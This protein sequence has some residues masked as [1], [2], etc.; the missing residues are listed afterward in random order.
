[1][2]KS[3]VRLALA[4]DV[5]VCVVDRH[6]V[7]LDLGRDDYSAVPL[8]SMPDAD[9]VPAVVE[10][11]L[12]RELQRHRDDLRAAGLLCNAGSGHSGLVDFLAI[13]P[14]AGHVFGRDDS[15]C[16]GV[17]VPQSP[18]RIRLGDWLQFFLASWKA[19]RLLR[20]RH[21]AKIAAHVIRRKANRPVELNLDDLRRQLAIFRR[22][23][24]W[25]PRSYLCLWDSLALLEFLAA[26][27]HFPDWIYGVQVEPF[28][29]HCWLQV[30]DKVLNEDTEYAQQF[31]PIMLV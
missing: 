23:R 22:L 4:D 5:F 1:M 24:P 7:F 25:Y 14:V 31:V 29:A 21:I 19:S 15:R 3:P 28:G 10:E 18:P 16:Y 13:T 30:G 27:R 20:R 26:R 9:A 6:A 17:S 12:Q 11:F 2:E 8:L